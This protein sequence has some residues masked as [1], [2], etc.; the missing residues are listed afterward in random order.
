MYN[1]LRDFHNNYLKNQIDSDF[2]LINNV[3]CFAFLVHNHYKLVKFNI[4]KT[5]YKIKITAT[6][7]MRQR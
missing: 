5:N 3:N 6:Q 4:L 2:L 1:K 7:D